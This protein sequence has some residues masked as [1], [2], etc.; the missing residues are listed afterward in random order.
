MS[1]ICAQIEQAIQNNDS[2]RAFHFYGSLQKII[3][4]STDHVDFYNVLRFKDNTDLAM[5]KLQHK[6]QINS[7]FPQA[8][9]SIDETASLEQ[10]M[11]EEIHQ[12]LCM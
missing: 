5:D 12:I 8:D 11:N 10:I 7:F 2:S 9:D 4:N 1:Q 6:E 3:E